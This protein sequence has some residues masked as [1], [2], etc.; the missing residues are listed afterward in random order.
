MSVEEKMIPPLRCVSGTPPF[1]VKTRIQVIGSDSLYGGKS[2]DGCRI[3][4]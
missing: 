4:R 1:W 3:R 2:E